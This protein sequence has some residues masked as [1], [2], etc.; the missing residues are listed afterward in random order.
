MSDP[1]PRWPSAWLDEQDV[2]AEQSLVDHAGVE[3]VTGLRGDGQ[4]LLSVT[5]PG[6]RRYMLVDPVGGGV[7]QALRAGEKSTDPETARLVEGFWSQ[8]L[9][10]AKKLLDGD[11]D[12][13]EL[14]AD[15]PPGGKRRRWR[16]GR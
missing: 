15:D 6:G 14:P 11:L 13:L 8:A 7:P 5:W 9:T 12:A 10:L 3:L 2:A 4:V 1:F 16:R